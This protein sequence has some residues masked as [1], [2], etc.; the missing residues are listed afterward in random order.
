[1]V[2]I[3]NNKWHYSHS[4][5]RQTAEH[6]E[7]IFGRT[8]G[9]CYPVDVATSK[10]GF[11]YV[12]SRGFGYMEDHGKE[13]PVDLY[14]RISKVTLDEDHVG[15]IARNQFTWPSSIAI[16][17]NGLL[18]CSDE[19]EN[20]IKV[21]SPDAITPFPEVN[22]TGDHV[23]KW[24]KS[25]SRKGYLN[26]PSGIC[27]GA[28][29]HLFIVDSNNDRIQV[30]TDEGE[31]VNCWGTTGKN[32]GEF[33]KPWGIVCDKNDDVYVSDWGNNRVQK[34]SSDGK[35]I[36]NVGVDSNH[37]HSLNHPAG[38]AVDNEG[39]I[40]VTDWGN[41]RVQIY[42]ANGNFVSSLGGDIKAI[43]S[44][45]EH[46]VWWRIVGNIQGDSPET[47]NLLKQT[48]LETRKYHCNFFGPTGITIDPDDNIIIADDPGRLI[49]YKKET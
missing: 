8:G 41:K 22:F 27:F 28:N 38:V 21:F 49:V 25:G 2:T 34:F 29:N 37:N 10:D 16:G 17:E 44:K 12:L 15:D 6:N 31:F 46:Y 39:L 47:R 3:T 9:F 43:N 5:G 45:A 36:L 13:Y 35:H 1:M 26:G 20:V 11:L 40:Y 42:T 30:F 48:Q 24:G 14:M 19:H 23:R 18:F 7:S 4:L 33:N 32:K